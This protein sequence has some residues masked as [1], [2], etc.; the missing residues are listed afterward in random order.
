MTNVPVVAQTDPSEQLSSPAADTPPPSLS[1]LE[2]FAP[3]NDSPSAKEQA[4]LAA[5]QQAALTYGLQG[6]LAHGLA[7]IDAIVRSHAQFLTQTY[8]FGA[9]MIDGPYGTKILPPVI[10]ESDQI[11]DQ[12]DADTVV[13]A[14]HTYKILQPAAFAPI[15]P[16]WQTY[17][18]MAWTAPATPNVKD[19][20]DSALEHRTWDAA[21]QKGYKIGEDQAF[22]EFQINLNSLN[23]EYM[24][25]IRWSRLVTTGEATVPMVTAE[26]RPVVGGGN[27]VTIDEGKVEIVSAAQLLARHD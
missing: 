23:R 14:N 22:S 19:F 1:D 15:Q 11:Y 25:M 26:M 21:L 20:P 4:R 3:D 2:S 27:E 7:Q 6:G 17:L 5:V 13:V 24:G 16:L 9:L 8:D 12:V 18:I 10:V